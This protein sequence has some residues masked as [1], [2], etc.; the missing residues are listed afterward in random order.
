M[1]EIID[2]EKFKKKKQ[3]AKEEQEKSEK[4]KNTDQNKDWIVPEGQKNEI[5]SVEINLRYT[6]EMQFYDIKDFLGNNFIACNYYHDE[7][8]KIIKIDIPKITYGDTKELDEFLKSKNIEYEINK[9][10][11]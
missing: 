8:R 10:E 9:L 6:S 4:I 2:F 1:G 3:E 5:I 11:K 7:H